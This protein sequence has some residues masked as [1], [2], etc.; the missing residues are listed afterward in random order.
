M[1]TVTTLHLDRLPSLGQLFELFNAGRHLNRVAEPALWAEL[2]AQQEQYQLLFARLGFRLCIDGRGFAWFQFDTAGANVSRTTRQLALLL[3]LLFEHKA[4]DG[5]HLA[6]FTDWQ[7]DQKL[8]AALAERGRELL[9]AEGLTLDA[10]GDLLGKACAQGFAEVAGGGWRLL[11]AVW[12]YLDHFEVLVEQQ[13]EDA[14][15]QGADQEAGSDFIEPASNE[16]EIA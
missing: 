8:L 14:D 4:D 1:N 3:M 11:P 10:L 15:E 9:R 12:R 13:R 16:D 2:E 5:Q 6:R 7:I